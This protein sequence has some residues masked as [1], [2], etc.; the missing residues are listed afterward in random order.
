[1]SKKPN[2]QVSLD[3]LQSIIRDMESGKIPVDQ[4]SG[5][6]KR[7][8]ELI[9]ICKNILSTTEEDVG[10]ILAEL[11]TDRTEDRQD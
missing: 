10:T 4:L 5:Y 1:M 11:D 2:Y 6:V 7:A 9:K 8:A 3:E